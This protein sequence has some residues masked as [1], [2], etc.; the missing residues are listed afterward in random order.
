MRR[1]VLPGSDRV[2]RGATFMVHQGGRQELGQNFLV[3]D[4]V[5]A[6]IGDLVA[7]TTGPIVE[8]GAGDGALTLPLSRYLRGCPHGRSGRLPP[9]TAACSK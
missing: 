6:H 3:D 1:F 5:I 8:L 9:S 2:I 4:S 7:E